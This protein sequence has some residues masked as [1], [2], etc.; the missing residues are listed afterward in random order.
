MR[1]FRSPL[2]L[3]VALLIAGALTVVLTGV[4]HYGGVD[5]LQLR[6]RSAVAAHRPLPAALLPAVTP[7]R[8]P[9]APRWDPALIPPSATPRPP[10]PVATPTAAA[11]PLPLVA[12]APDAGVQLPTATVAPAAIIAP[13]AALPTAVAL[14][15]LRHEWQTWNNCGPATLAMN[16]SY[17]GSTLDQAAIGAVLRR[18]AD[19]KNVSPDEL[20]AFAQAQGMQAAVRVNGSADLLRALVAAG[21]PV[22]IETWLEEHPNDGMGH[23]RL[24]TGYDDTAQA[25]I[26]YDSYVSNGLVLG[27]GAKDGSAADEYRGIY[28]PYAQAAEWWKVFNHTYVLAYPPAAGVEVQAILGDTFDTSGQWAAAE[29][30]ARAALAA[31]PND[32]FAWFNLGSSLWA[33]GRATEAVDAFDQAR[34]IGLPWRMLWYQFAPF[35]AYSAVGRHADVLTLADATLA[36][37]DSIEEIYYWKARALAALGDAPGAR[38]ALDRALSLYPGYGDAA[39][40]RA[41]IGL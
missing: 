12:D 32:A 29:A 28:F 7:A 41:A 16:L 24:I 1:I 40:L 39:T 38:A 18:S 22:L 27:G 2:L 25:W 21:Y 17:F 19:D 37:T 20:A 8:D 34:A 35:A 5:G 3:I 30:T 23:Y 6:L 36:N 9:G 15:G 13:P 14:S 26:A 11:T 4:V 10:T 31:N 33:M